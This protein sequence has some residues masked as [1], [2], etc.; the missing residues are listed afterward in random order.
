MTQLINVIINFFIGLT[1]LLKLS[2]L[3]RSVFRLILYLFKLSADTIFIQV[4]IQHSS[5]SYRH[6]S[7]FL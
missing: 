2:A 3:D 4:P 6:T 1:S 7:C 5:V